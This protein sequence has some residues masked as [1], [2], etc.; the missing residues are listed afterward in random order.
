MKGDNT[1]ENSPKARF[2][3]LSLLHAD[4]MSDVPNIEMN[5]RTSNA[6]DIYLRSGLPAI[7]K[8]RKFI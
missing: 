2:P 7:E 1:A 6:S 5:R 4:T 8:R 3:K